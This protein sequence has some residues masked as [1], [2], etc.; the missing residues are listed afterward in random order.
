[1]NTISVPPSPV[2][3]SRWYLPVAVVLGSFLLYAFTLTKHYSEGEDSAAYVREVTSPKSIRDY[4]FPNHLAFIP[5]N[6]GVFLLGRAAGY[7]G[8]ASL[9]M[10][11]LNALAGAIALGLMVLILETLE[12]DQRL[13][14]C[15]VGVTAVSFGL[16][17]YSTQAETYT[18]PLPPILLCIYLIMKLPEGGFSYK[19]FAAL[20]CSG[21]IATLL[22]QQHVLVLSAITIAAALTGFRHRSEVPSGRIAA[23]LGILCFLGALIVGVAY[24]S[25]A[26]GVLHL[27]DP[28]AIIQWSKGHAQNGLWIPWS[29]TNPIQSLIVGFP[30]TVLGGHFL[31]GFDSFYGPVSRRFP[32]RLLIEERYLGQHIPSWIRLTCLAATMI[33]TASAL[34]VARTFFF[35][36]DKE[37]PSGTRK[38]RYQAAG[39]IVVLLI[40]HYYIF[41]TLWE[42]TCIEFW[43]VL[44]PVVGI[45]IAS[46]QTRRPKA[47][48]WWLA[49]AVLAASLLIVNGLGSILPQTTLDT[50]YWYQAN[51]YLIENARAGDL[52]VTDGRFISNM[53]LR[54]YTNADV[55][56]AV[57]WDN[58]R[59]PDEVLNGGFKR[60]WI[61][62]WAVDPPGQAGWMGGTPD[63]RKQEEVRRFV[64]SLRDRLTKRDESEFQTVW[65]L[66]QRTPR[67]ANLQG[68]RL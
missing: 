16:W 28:A 49:T 29:N 51:R 14:M 50:D 55:V 4:F 57:I 60:V 3:I 42:P 34:A 24:L 62:S 38:V 66:T 39:T 41:N 11:L 32:G 27:V 12:V 25:V 45:A 43:I 33:V 5:L 46:I 67:A 6:R 61:S 59:S 31:Y 47:R 20:G 35:S 36:S 21:A 15:W 64:E 26:I 23:G 7:Q 22:H 58:T 19:S 54:L 8:D 68:S 40:L 56:S 9:T 65:E 44:L 37:W 18:L 53:Y 1:V 63:L 52:I 10:K 13:M 2:R 48:Q 30:R 17:S